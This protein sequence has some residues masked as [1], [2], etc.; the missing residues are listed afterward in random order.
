MI[1]Q[2]DAHGNHVVVSTGDLTAMGHGF[3]HF[4]GANLLHLEYIK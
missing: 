3:A 1:D 4:C 2:I